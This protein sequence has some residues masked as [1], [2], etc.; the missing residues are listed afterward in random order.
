LLLDPSRRG[1]LAEKLR[2][3]LL[4][5]VVGQEAGVDAIVD[6]YEADCAG[7]LAQGRPV[8]NFL[9]LGPTGCGKTRTVEATAKSLLGNW[10]GLTK[11]DCGEFQ[12]SHEIAKLIGS[13]PGYLSHRE[14]TAALSQRRIDEYATATCK[15]SIVLFDEIEK[16]RLTRRC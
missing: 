10:R 13:P 3:D 4:S 2:G 7:M 5:F 12:H 8:A 16:A 9:F 11:V 1:S 6:A 15:L 14:T